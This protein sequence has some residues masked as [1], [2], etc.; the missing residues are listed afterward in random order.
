MFV[1]V[2]M[3][4]AKLGRDPGEEV[5]MAGKGIGLKPEWKSPKVSEKNH[6]E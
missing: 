2:R 5:G 4:Q 3:I 1:V 6:P